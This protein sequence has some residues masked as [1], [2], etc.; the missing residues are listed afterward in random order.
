MLTNRPST[1]AGES[2]LPKAPVDVLAQ[3]GEDA[4]EV[5]QDLARDAERH[6]RL[7]P[8]ARRP[9]AAQEPGETPER[10]LQARVA[11]EPPH[12]RIVGVERN[13]GR[14]DGARGRGHGLARQQG[15]VATARQ[16]Q[17]GGAGTAGQQGDALLRAQLVQRHAPLRERLG[18][19][20][21]ASVPVQDPADAH[22]DLERVRERDHLAD[23]AHRRARHRRREARVQ[24]LG[25][26]IAQLGAHAGPPSQEAGEPH[27]DQGARLLRRQPGG[28]SH[29]TA[30]QQVALVGADLRLGQLVAGEEALAGRDPVDRSPRRQRR[31]KLAVPGLHPRPRG[32]PHHHATPRERDLLDLVAPQPVGDDGAR[33]LVS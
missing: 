23:A 27:G 22:E 25:Q 31:Q 14:V 4:L 7:R 30:Q 28:R 15:P 5:G 17:R 3:A 32:L 11:H 10:V 29:G 21:G 2:S 13:T 8:G 6:R 1:S 19:R 12:G 26:A 18:G 16:G 20:P 33:H 9:S 24:D